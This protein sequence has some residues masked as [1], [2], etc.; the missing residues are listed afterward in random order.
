M[1]AT[2]WALKRIAKFL[3]KRH[4]GRLLHGDLDLDTLDIALGSGSL[5][6]RSLLLDCD[7]IN[8]QLLVC[9]DRCVACKLRPFKL[10]IDGR[11]RAQ[12]RLV[13]TLAPANCCQ[14]WSST[15]HVERHAAAA[16][17]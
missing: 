14:Q 5:S 9:S 7:Y 4:L 12:S 11:N 16:Y 3:L 17:L 2:D 1:G 6:L 8:T 10:F 13:G 15:M